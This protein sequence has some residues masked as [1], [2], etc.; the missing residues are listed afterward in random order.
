MEGGFC[1]G[2]AIRRGQQDKI[3]SQQGGGP[4]AHREG[5]NYI[6]GLAKVHDSY[7]SA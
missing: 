3:E 7:D 1:F 5:S 6:L 4:K 2:A